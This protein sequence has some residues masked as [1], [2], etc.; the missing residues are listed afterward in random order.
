MWKVLYLSEAR[1]ERGKLPIAERKAVDN[2]VSQLEVNGPSLPY[3]HSSK[4]QGAAKLRELR[5][6]GGPSPW[7]ALYRQYGDAFIIAAVCPEAKKD[8]RGFSRGVAAAEQR[9]EKLE[10]D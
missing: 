8:R 4:V 7:R 1:R 9:L 6:R 10:E 5:P 3:P 2:A